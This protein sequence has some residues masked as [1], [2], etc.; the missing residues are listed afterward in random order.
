MLYC[1][2]MWLKLL[3]YGVYSAGT[4]VSVHTGRMNQVKQV[5]RSTEASV[6]VPFVA[7]SL[8]AQS[9]FWCSASL[10]SGCCATTLV[11]LVFA[12]PLVPCSQFDIARQ[13]ARAWRAR[14]R[15]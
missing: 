7:R 11:S 13:V 2:H 8:F 3:I 1:R 5:Q 15:M 14:G 9:K 6:C 10:F 4:W 12:G